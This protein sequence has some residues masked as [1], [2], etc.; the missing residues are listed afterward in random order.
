MKKL[1]FTPLWAV[2]L[3]WVTPLTLVGQMA[4]KASLITDHNTS[5][6][7]VDPINCYSGMNEAQV[8]LSRGELALYPLTE[9][10]IDDHFYSKTLVEL[11]IKVLSPEAKKPLNHK[12]CFNL[13]MKSQIKNKFGDT[14][15]HNASLEEYGMDTYASFPGGDQLLFDFVACKLLHLRDLFNTYDE[16]YSITFNINPNGV[17]QEI[18]TTAPPSA[19]IQQALTEILR[20]SP[21]WTPARSNGVPV[22]Q[23]LTL[24]IPDF[25]INPTVACN[26]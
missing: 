2:M 12:K 7:H 21:Q 6:L 5:L 15:L 22:P 26:P 17:V 24:P 1:Y 9:L 16:P 13:F 11:N 4:L 23:K 3:I 20:E 8:F 14:H 10:P 25:T 18:E 19:K